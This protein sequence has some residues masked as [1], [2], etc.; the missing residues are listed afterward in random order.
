MP[1]DCAGDVDVFLEE[2]AITVCGLSSADDGTFFVEIRI[3]IVVRRDWF[4]KGGQ[5]LL[6]AVEAIVKK[7]RIRGIVISARS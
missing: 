7:S 4:A 3:R 1:K 6:G 2:F 5:G